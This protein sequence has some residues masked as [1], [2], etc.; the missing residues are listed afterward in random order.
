MRTVTLLATGLVLSFP[1]SAADE[2]LL[3]CDGVS[4]H[5]YETQKTNLLDH[6]ITIKVV[7]TMYR[8]ARVAYWKSRRNRGRC[9]YGPGGGEICARCSISTLFPVD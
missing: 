9:W 7:G 1:I 5:S 4:L 6:Q 3:I 2:T 8:Q